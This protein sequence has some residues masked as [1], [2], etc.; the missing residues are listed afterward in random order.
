VSATNAQKVDPADVIAKHKAAIGTA[1]A[2]SAIK[3]QLILSDVRFTIK[4]AAAAIAGKAVLLSTDTK[5]L[6]GMNFA[7]NYYPQDRF[8]FDGSNVRVAKATTTDRS[9]I[10]EFLYSN[11]EIIREGLLGGTW[12]A[13]WPLL[14]TEPRNAK[15]KYDGTK[16]INGRDTIVLTYEPK[17]PS[18]LTIK[19]YFDSRGYQHLRTEYTLTRAA[20]QGSTIDTSARQTSTIYR[21]VED[22]SNFS[23]MGQLNLPGVYKLTFIRTGA[24]PVEAEWAFTMTD[25]GFNRE[26]DDNSFNVEAK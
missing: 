26:I 10:G 1:A 19:I 23:K 13:A 6:W 12:S 18:D 4:G 11:R 3:N 5:T 21:L 16:T 20:T 14:D 24:A 8:G 9:L 2:L 15:I 17:V 22:F 25:I 7:S